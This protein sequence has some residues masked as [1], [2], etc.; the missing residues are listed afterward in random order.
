MVALSAEQK[1]ADLVASW[2]DATAGSMADSKVDR[3][4]VKWALSMV[5]TRAVTTAA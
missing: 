2:A 3:K 1:A 5:A 4:V